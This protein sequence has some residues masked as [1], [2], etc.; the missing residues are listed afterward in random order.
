MIEPLEALAHRAKFTRRYVSKPGHHGPKSME[1]Y[2]DDLAELVDA[3]E[4]ARQHG[5][6]WRD[7]LGQQF[8]ISVPLDQVP[9]LVDPGMLVEVDGDDG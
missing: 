7:V 4:W 9:E 5:Y 2:V 1:V 6:A 3:I 8:Q